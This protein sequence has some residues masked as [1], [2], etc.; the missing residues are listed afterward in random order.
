MADDP[1]IDREK[2]MKALLE[3]CQQLFANANATTGVCM[4]GGSMSNHD[5]P[6]LCGHSPVDSGSYYQSLLA[7]DID[8]FLNEGGVT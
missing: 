6:M 2:R 3:S 1:V 7:K 5:N 8:D 4:C